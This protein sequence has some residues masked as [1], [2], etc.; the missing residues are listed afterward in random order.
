MMDRWNLDETRS[1]PELAISRS[2]KGSSFNTKGLPCIV[3][4]VTKGI[5]KIHQKNSGALWVSEKA[6]LKSGEKIVYMKCW[7]PLC[8]KEICGKEQFDQHGWALVSRSDLEKLVGSPSV[9]D[10]AKL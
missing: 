5:I 10:H 3:H 2:L 9:S 4:M 7:H 8:Q 1:A 6:K